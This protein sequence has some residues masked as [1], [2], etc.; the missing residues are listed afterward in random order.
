MIIMQN[1]TFED[2]KK[3]NLWKRK[4]SQSK[5]FFDDIDFYLKSAFEGGQESIVKEAERL[6]KI[7]KKTNEP[8]DY[9]DST[10]LTLIK[11]KYGIGKQNTPIPP[12]LKR[13]GSLGEA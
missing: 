8:I 12:R 3:K 2:W 11:Q 1:K 7:Y 6:L 10:D 4:D 9:I 5:K 13:R